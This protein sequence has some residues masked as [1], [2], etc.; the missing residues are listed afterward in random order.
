MG[1]IRDRVVN[2]SRLSDG[3]C[4]KTASISELVCT[5]SLYMSLMAR[6][7]KM[8]DL[9]FKAGKNNDSVVKVLDIGCSNAA[10]YQLYTSKNFQSP[11]RKKIDYIGVDLDA[12]QLKHAEVACAIIKSTRFTSK[13]VHADITEPYTWVPEG[14]KADIIWYTEVIEHVPREKAHLTLKHALD[15]SH[16][17]TIMYLAT[18]ATLDGNLVWPD[19][20]DWEYTREELAQVLDEQGWQVIDM[21][22]VDADW[23]AARK[24]LRETNKPMFDLYETLRKRIGSPLAAAA[25][26]ALCPEVCRDLAWICKPKPIQLI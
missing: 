19:S 25:V 23:Q 9:V 17:D 4:N 21:Y 24:M 12:I 6:H 3:T 7:C 8:N 14:W 26:Q 15:V 2:G 1:N 22:G 10:A 20:H 16:D 13:I 11:G 18:P 5:S